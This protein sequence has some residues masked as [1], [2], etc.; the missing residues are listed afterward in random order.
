MRG[1]LVIAQSGGPTMVINESVVGAVPGFLL[2]QAPV[3]PVPDPD[4][5]VDQHHR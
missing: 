4:T 3:Y 1:K 5:D 2:V